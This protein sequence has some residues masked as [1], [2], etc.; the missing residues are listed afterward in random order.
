MR[1]YR[2]SRP[3]SHNSCFKWISSWQRRQRQ[4][5]RVLI[6][7]PPEWLAMGL[8]HLLRASL[9][10]RILSFLPA[11]GAGPAVVP[12]D[13]GAKIISSR[14]SESLDPERGRNAEILL[15][16]THGCAVFLFPDASPDTCKKRSN[17]RTELGRI[18][19][20]ALVKRLGVLDRR[21]R[22]AGRHRR[23]LTRK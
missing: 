8:P 17:V 22:A 11:A 13:E 15:A 20:P 14:T 6:T 9:S 12:R 16:G 5:E 4:A 18:P 19:E 1:V 10:Q 23:E 3:A 7:G 2:S 21:G